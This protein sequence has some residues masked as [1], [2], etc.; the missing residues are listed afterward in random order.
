MLQVFFLRFYLIIKV[1]KQIKLTYKFKIQ[2]TASKMKDRNSN[3]SFTTTLHLDLY[4]LRPFHTSQAYANGQ[5][6]VNLKSFAA[7][8][9]LA[10]RWKTKQQASNMLVLYS[11]EFFPK[12]IYFN[13]AY[14]QDPS[15]DT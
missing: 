14:V 11:Q 1:F 3:I 10:N 5:I 15:E 8:L 12:C 6:D 7:H 2:V 13:K 4:W 9:L